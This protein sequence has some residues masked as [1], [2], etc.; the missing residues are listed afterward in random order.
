MK[1]HKKFILCPD[2]QLNSFM[3]NKSIQSLLLETFYIHWL[4]GYHKAP[5]SI[6]GALHH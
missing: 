1:V 4:E 5:R 2:Y 3:K 6:N